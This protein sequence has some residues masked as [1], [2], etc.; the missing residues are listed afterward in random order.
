MEKRF[1]NTIKYNTFSVDLFHAIYGIFF[2]FFFVVVVVVKCS[3]L[4]RKEK[5]H[6]TKSALK[7]EKGSTLKVHF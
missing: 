3:H 7:N 1:P 6:G 4:F 5:S 2:F